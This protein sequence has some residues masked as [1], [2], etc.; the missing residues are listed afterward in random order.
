MNQIPITSYVKIPAEQITDPV[1]LATHFLDWIRLEPGKKIGFIGEPQAGATVSM[2]YLELISGLT[3]IY[4]PRGIPDT[5]NGTIDCFSDLQAII[6][7]DLA[8]WIED[9]R[10]A[11]Y[12]NERMVQRVATD[13]T[14]NNLLAWK[15]AFS[16]ICLRD[17]TVLAGRQPLYIYDLPALPINYNHY[18]DKLVLIKRRANWPQDPAFL[19]H[20]VKENVSAET[21]IG[22]IAVR[23][24]QFADAKRD[25][26]WAFDYE[27]TNDGDFDHLEEQLN[28]M[29][30]TMRGQ[31]DV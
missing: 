13:P 21:E 23:D 2:H 15:D 22:L 10:G 29:V 25:G 4:D 19:E 11:P 30:T 5:I 3:T 31:L 8:N 17:H 24:Q 12:T 27:F 9:L 16:I 26:G 28:T 20:I 6:E 1:S 14:V 7:T 18:F